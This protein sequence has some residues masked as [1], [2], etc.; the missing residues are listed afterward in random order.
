MI[1]AEIKP[2]SKGLLDNAKIFITK[3][4]SP[5]LVFEIG[6]DKKNNLSYVNETINSCDK[7]LPFINSL[8]GLSLKQEDICFH[9]FSQSFSRDPKKSKNILL[10]ISLGKNIVSFLPLVGNSPLSDNFINFQLED[11]D[12]FILSP[13]AL[14]LKSNNEYV[15]RYACG[16]NPMEL[17]QQEIS[18]IEEGIPKLTNCRVSNIRPKYNDL[19]EW[20]TNDNNVYIGKKGVVFI[21]DKATG[22]QERF[23]KENSIYACS[24]EN[25]S[26]YKQELLAK[27]KNGEIDISELEGKTLGCWCLPEPCHG[28]IIIDLYVKKMLDKF[29]FVN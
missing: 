10:S 26:N 25:I 4:L 11:G 8:Y 1:K 27:I 12:V 15:L 19:R 17:F 16:S 21:S 7:I 3:Q 13:E 5:G 20:M 2:F 9:L 23:P 6:T 24:D 28:Q 18:S 29:F 14:G 22:K